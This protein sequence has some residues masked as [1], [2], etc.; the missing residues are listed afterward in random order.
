MPDFND[1]SVAEFSHIGHRDENQD[2]CRVFTDPQSGV[3]LAV[4]ADGMGGHA[5]GGLAAAT[6]AQSAAEVWQSRAAG[7]AP[8]DFL[9]RLIRESHRAVNVAGQAQ[10]ITPRATVAALLI[11]LRG[12]APCCVSIHAGD[13]RI[14]QYAA[15]RAVTQSVDHSLAQLH[16]LRGKITQEQAA[17]HP[18]QSRV[19]TSVGGEETPEAEITQWDLTQGG[20]FVVCSDG[21]WEIF[22]A[23]DVLRLFRVTRGETKTGLQSPALLRAT[24]DM[25]EQKLKGLKKQDNTTAVLIELNATAQARQSAPEPRPVPDRATR[26]KWPVGFTVSLFGIVVIA[27]LALI[28]LWTL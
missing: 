12:D 22:K 4:V 24:G 3:L 10:G 1:I 5:G 2:R 13:C 7:E 18:D 20:R 6:V 11:Q 15:E 27:L 14:T 16:V 21:F 26:A 17:T 8:S 28:A 25:F 19:L 9:Q 23:E